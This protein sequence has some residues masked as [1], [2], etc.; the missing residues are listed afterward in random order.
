[1]TRD[2]II[3]ALDWSPRFVER[4]ENSL[5]ARVER[6]MAQAVAAEREACAKACE[7]LRDLRE[8]ARAALRAADALKTGDEDDM[9]RALRHES[10]VHL[11]NCGLDHAAAVIRAR[12][13]G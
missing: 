3:K 7:D 6:V 8:E 12:G 9:L 4:D 13:Q 5:L 1:M 11:Y 10:N 2:D